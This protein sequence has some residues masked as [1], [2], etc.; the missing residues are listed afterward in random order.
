[1]KKALLL[2]IVAV[3]GMSCSNEDGPTEVPKK[4]K[5][6]FEHNVNNAEFVEWDI[7]GQN[8]EVDFEV[9][10]KKQ[11][12]LYNA[13]GEIIVKAKEMNTGALPEAIIVYI[14]NQYSGAEIKEVMAVSGAQMNYFEIELFV[15][16]EKKELYFNERGEPFDKDEIEEE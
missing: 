12:L 4:V 5:L 16:G 9:N 1:M 10:G 13:Q 3:V 11:E 2:V 15:K 6:M 14:D 7:E 8:F